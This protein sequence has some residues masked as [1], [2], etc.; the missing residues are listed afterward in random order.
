MASA[1]PGQSTASG[2]SATLAPR[3]AKIAERHLRNP[4]KVQIAREKTA[5]GK[6]MHLH[7][8]FNYAGRTEIVDAIRAIVRSGTA[9]ESIDESLVAANLYTKEI[10]DPDLLI[11]TAGEMRLS[12]FLLW[13]INGAAVYF[14]EK[15]WP[16]FD[17]VELDKALELVRSN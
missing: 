14:T 13:Q 1:K 6:R 5:A 10:P 11:R 8:A 12:N 2:A 15:T 3:I 4:R 7:V 9:S 17:S 16:D